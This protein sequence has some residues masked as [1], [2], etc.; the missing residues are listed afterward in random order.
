MDAVRRSLLPPSSFQFSLVLLVLLLTISD[1]TASSDF[2]DMIEISNISQNIRISEIM[3]I[4]GD[5]QCEEENE[6]SLKLDTFIGFGSSITEIYS[7]VD[8]LLNPCTKKSAVEDVLKQL[9]TELAETKSNI[10]QIE[11]KL[12]KEQVRAYQDAEG[13][14]KIALS[15]LKLKISSN[16]VSKA[17]TLFDHLNTFMHGMPELVQTVRD[18][19]DVSFFFVQ[20]N[21]LERLHSLCCYSVAVRV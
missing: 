10:K 11:G 13:S 18:I 7:Y 1:T 17:N 12:T 4:R 8:Y 3:E 20:N 2:A 15:D 14:I 21:F 5:K 16:L 9:E 19:Y 6:G